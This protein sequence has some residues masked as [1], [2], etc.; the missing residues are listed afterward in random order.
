MKRDMKI[1]FYGS[2]F[3]KEVKMKCCFAM[4]SGVGFLIENEEDAVSYK[5]AIKVQHPGLEDLLLSKVPA[6]GGSE[7]SYL[8]DVEI[9][10]TLRQAEDV[11]FKGEI[12]NIKKL[13]LFVSGLE[14]S[15]L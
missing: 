2:D 6:F 13:N 9:I 11:K 12:T 3:N 7:Y 10:G 1:L 5:N 4:R 15:V 8:C 14:F